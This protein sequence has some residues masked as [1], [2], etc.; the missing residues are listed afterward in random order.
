MFGLKDIITLK[1]LENM[2]KVILTTSLIV[3]YAYAMEFFIA[4]YSGNQKE[5]FTFRHRAF[6]PYAWAYWIMISC[7]VIAPQFLWSKRIRTSVWAMFAVAMCVNVGMW[8]ERF[9]IVT[10]LTAGFIPSSWE[11][12]RPTWIDLLTLLGSFGLFG[13]LFLLFC[14]YL[15]IVAIAEVKTVMPQAAGEHKLPTELELFD[16][17]QSVGN[18]GETNEQAKSH[19]ATAAEGDSQQLPVNRFTWLSWTRRPIPAEVTQPGALHS[20]LVQFETVDQLKASAC[21]VRDAGY[22][23]WDTYSPFPVHGIDQAMGIRR[24]RLP[25]LVLLFG[26]TGA[27]GGLF[28]QWWLN[29]SDPQ[30]AWGLPNFLEGY[31]FRISGK[32]LWKVPANIPVTFELTILFASVS[33]FIGLLVANRLLCWSQPLFTARLSPRLTNDRFALRIGAN[34]ALFDEVRTGELLASLGVLEVEQVRV[35][36]PTPAPVWLGPAWTLVASLAVLLLSFVYYANHNPSTQPRIQVSADM[37]NQERFKAQQANPLFAD[38]R[39]MRAPVAGTIAQGDAW[40]LGHDKHFYEGQVDGQ[41]ADTLPTRV[42]VNSELLSSGQECF[43]IYCAACHGY[44]GSGSGMVAQRV[45]ESPELSTGFTPPS[46][47]HDPAIRDR[48]LGFHFNTITN[49]IRSMPAHG[50]QIPPADRWAIAAYIRALQLSR[51]ALLDDAPTIE[52]IKLKK[53]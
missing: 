52:Q 28:G 53:L 37:D 31:D 38:G 32:P 30:N 6:G 29:S 13:T 48:V 16:S 23:A 44:D 24:S 49:G 22:R 27:V 12:Y 50:K 4:W 45:R 20:L 14:R 1:H 9:V 36:E 5:A 40:Q 46:S 39:A 33:A 17:S 25:W 8:F 3:G 15:P 7:N 2:N 10:T 21:R 41:W 35:P 51:H 47:L 34:D 26:I 42:K 11:Y 43:H 18:S 19:F